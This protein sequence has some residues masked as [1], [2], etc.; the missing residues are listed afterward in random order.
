[1]RTAR[2]IAFVC[3]MTLLIGSAASA[4]SAAEFFKG[5]QMTLVIGFNVGGA[6]DPYG[7]TLVRHMPKHLPGGPNFIVR[8]MQGA[9]SINAAN[10]IYNRAPRDGSEFGLVAGTAPLEP[11][12]G[13][14]PTQFD[15]QKFTWIG[16]ANTEVG[17]C[18]SWHESPIKTVQDLFSR[19]MITGAAGSTTVSFPDGLNAMLG[20]KLKLVKGYPGVAAVW[21]AMERREV[22]GA[23]GMIYSSLQAAHPDWLTE[24]KVNTLI[25]IGYRKNPNLPDVPFVMDLAKTEEERQV[26]NLLFGWTVMG[27]PFLAPPEVPADRAAA[28]RKAFDDTMKDPAFLEETA[29]LRLDIDPLP[30][31]EIDKFLAEIFKTPKPVVEKANAIL[32]TSR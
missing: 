14:I 8:N 28:L 19:E 12:F 21:I 5:R 23:C 30:G 25:Q 7:R 15:S 29:K 27:R 17:A 2:L 24:K 32:G 22:E 1:M 4:Q 16:S 3:L 9:G 20:T 11:L 6:F 13:V 31:A 10:Y 18:F 26:F